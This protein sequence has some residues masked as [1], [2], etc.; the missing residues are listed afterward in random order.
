MSEQEESLATGDETLTAGSEKDQENKPEDVSVC[1]IF[2]KV[3]I[4]NR[5]E[6]L[7]LNPTQSLPTF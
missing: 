3:K 6:H 1:S 4:V 2:S 5:I 7:R